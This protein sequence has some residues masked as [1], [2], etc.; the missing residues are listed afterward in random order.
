M[1]TITRDKQPFAAGLTWLAGGLLF[2]W[3]AIGLS[4]VLLGGIFLDG[5]AHRH[6]PTLESFFTPWHGV[7][8]SGY[9]LLTSFLLA[10]TLA[11]GRGSR[12]WSGA[13][14]AGY[15]LALLGGLIFAVGGV[16][17]L[18]WHT[19]FGIEDGIEALLSPTHLLL[20][21]GAV[22]LVSGPLRAAWARAESAP[23]T[24]WL[25]QVPSILAMGYSLSVLSFMTM[26]SHPFV[27][28]VAHGRVAPA[29]NDELIQGFGIN[30]IVV[31]TA[32]LMGAILLLTGRGRLPFGGLTLLFV[33]NAVLLSA[34]DDQY[35]T[36][37]LALV[38]GLFADI[39]NH[40]LRPAGN[41]PTAL[42]VFATLVPMVWT[43][44][45]FALLI[46]TGGIWWSIHVWAGTICLS[47]IAGLLL[48]LLVTSDTTN[49]TN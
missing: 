38:T 30:G 43:S 45:Y 10:V 5:W 47:G 25:A 24:G 29:R 48:S 31:G 28:I 41:R 4:T 19:A 32:L 16:G 12:D 17:D 9:G 35:W 44:L 37:G 7:L 8:Y 42:R 3:V 2:D 23:Q 22:L 46:L 39:V 27:E 6:I 36:I 40:Q 34:L 20:A 13:I 49:Q 11:N 26:Y 21:T 14:P 33:L 15:G 1:A 18:L